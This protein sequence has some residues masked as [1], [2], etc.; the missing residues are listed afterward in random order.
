M[1][2][3]ILVTSALIIF[4]SG[5]SHTNGSRLSDS[6]RSA[7]A[8][9]YV[10]NHGNDERHLEL[11]VAEIL[12][13]RGLKATTG[14]S[15]TRPNDAEYLVTYTDRWQWDMRMYLLEFTIMVSDFETGKRLGFGQSYQ[16]SLSAMGLTHK[17]VIERAVNELLGPQ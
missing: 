7:S 9:Y 12:R 14:S 8:T 3:S 13:E 1:K 15:A 6:N 11:T 16:D 5:C 4:S 2:F 17:D 10:E